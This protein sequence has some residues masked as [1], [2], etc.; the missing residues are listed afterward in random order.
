MRN[1]PACQRR[2]AADTVVRAHGIRKRFGSNEAVRAFDLEIGRGEVVALL[3]PNGAGKT[4]AVQILLGLR[5]PDAGT[6]VVLGH[7][8]G[9]IEARRRIGVTLQEMACPHLLRVGEIL[10][11]AQAHFPSST[12]YEPLLEEF[13]LASLAR[14]QIGGLS[15][16]E[17]RRLALALAFAGAPELVFLDEPTTGLDVE[18]RRRAWRA[19][20]GFAATGGTVL[21]TTH[22]LEEAEALAS[23]IAVMR[24]GRVVKIGR[25]EAIVGEVGAASLE[26]AFL[27]LT[28]ERA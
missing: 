23:R 20:R 6:A 5:R 27:L 10:S 15:G 24:D 28:R 22:Y 11:F 9:A 12:P 17:R 4:T 16:G 3:G 14:R 2:N 13:G 18:S 7:E 19:I 26:E 21:L 25:A 8:P 1:T